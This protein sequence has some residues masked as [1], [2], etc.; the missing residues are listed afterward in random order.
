M[1]TCDQVMKDMT[2]GKNLTDSER[3]DLQRQVTH[4]IWTDFKRTSKKSDQWT[5]KSNDTGYEYTTNIKSHTQ[6]SYLSSLDHLILERIENLFEIFHALQLFV[7][8]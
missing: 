4:D 5:P 6:M 2:F 7:C 3:K 8:P 1:A